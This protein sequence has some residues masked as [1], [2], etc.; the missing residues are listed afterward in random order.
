MLLGD[1]WPMITIYPTKPTF[2]SDDLVCNMAFITTICDTNG[3]QSVRFESRW[4][5][6]VRSDKIFGDLVMK[7][8]LQ[9][10]RQS[11]LVLEFWEETSSWTTSSSVLFWA[12]F[13]MAGLQRP[14]PRQ[15]NLVFKISNYFQDFTFSFILT[16]NKNNILFWSLTKRNFFQWFRIKGVQD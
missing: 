1:P 14:T 2:I 15:K 10:N 13:R 8:L 11:A 9:R 4:D 7:V 5:L 3:G 12:C 6:G 16:V